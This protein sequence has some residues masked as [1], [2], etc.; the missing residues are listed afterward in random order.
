MQ[1]SKCARS[2]K[3]HPG[4][5][6]PRQFIFNLADVELRDNT[7]PLCRLF[8]RWKTANMQSFRFH[9]LRGHHYCT[10]PFAHH[11][12]LTTTKMGLKFIPITNI[13]R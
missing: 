1:P 8:F 9:L 2:K 5:G 10:K 11:P 12:T 3:N 6:N 7:H 13:M 4:N